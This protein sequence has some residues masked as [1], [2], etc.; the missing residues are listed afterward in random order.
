MSNSS[1]QRNERKNG[2]LFK[3]GFAYNPEELEKYIKDAGLNERVK[4]LDALSEVNMINANYL[5]LR[6]LADSGQVHMY[7][8]DDN[9]HV[10][11]L[12]GFLEEY[13]FL[14]V[15]I[16]LVKEK[17][18]N[19]PPYKLILHSIRELCEFYYPDEN[20]ANWIRLI[21]ICLTTYDAYFIQAERHGIDDKDN[22]GCSFTA[23]IDDYSKLSPYPP[24]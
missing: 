11:Q 16:S 23:F 6:A 21:N 1:K 9:Y 4:D 24:Q 13:P 10:E 7:E 12:A 19:L 5:D 20:N 22:M 17:D 8:S 3:N 2:L 14:F 18:K 15:E